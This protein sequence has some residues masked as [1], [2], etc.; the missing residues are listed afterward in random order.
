MIP[1]ETAKEIL[2]KTISPLI[3]IYRKKELVPLTEAGGR[4]L[5][6]DVTA[7]MDV[8]SFDRSPVDGYALISADTQTATPTS[9]ILLTVIDMVAA[10]SNPSKS[11]STGTAIK[12]FTGAPLPLGADCVIKKEEVAEIDVASAGFLASD[13]YPS[14]GNLRSS[15][16]QSFSPISIRKSVIKGENVAGK[17]EDIAN[18]EFLFSAGTLL[19]PAHLGILATLGMDYVEVFERPKIGIFSTGN[20]LID[21]HAPLQNGKLRASN[22]YTLS[23]LIRQAGGIPVN[24]GLIKDRIDDVIA[25]YDRASEL[26]LPIVISTGGTASG[27]YDVIKDALDQISANRMFDKVAMRPGA[28]VLTATRK[29]QLIIGLSGNPAGA[30]VAM[31]L[32]VWPLIAQLAGTNQSLIST[33]GNLTTPLQRQGGL[34]GFLW[35]SYVDVASLADDSTESL[36]VT[37]DENQF[38]GAIKTYARSN[39]LIEIPAG[40]V[41]L[42]AGDKIKIWKLL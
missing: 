24:L 34:R 32:V 40:K 3:N 9:P 19:K 14:S 7:E 41:D 4:I 42:S 22:L 28:P 20:E 27:D 12:I 29:N 8:P 2:D 18:G 31:L 33:Y 17:G 5:A 21:V 37:P 10:G 25:A 36:H 15:D 39:C 35:G 23:E 30:T 16:H 11:L 6:N 13:D 26:Q 1:L 38:C